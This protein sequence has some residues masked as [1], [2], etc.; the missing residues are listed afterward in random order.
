MFSTI[1][2]INCEITFYRNG[3]VDYPENYFEEGMRNR[4][5]MINE[6]TLNLKDS[7]DSENDCDD[8]YDEN[9]DNGMSFDSSDYDDD[10]SSQSDITTSTSDGDMSETDDDDDD[11]NIVFALGL[12]DN[13]KVKQKSY[14]GWD[15][16]TC[17][18]HTD[19]GS[20]YVGNGKLPQSVY[21]NTID[22]GHT[23]GC[24]YIP[25]EYLA[26]FTING[27]IVKQTDVQSTSSFFA[28]TL[29]KCEGFEINT[30]LKPFKFD[31]YQRSI[32]DMFL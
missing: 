19:N 12:T 28:F 26:F 17:A 4:Q 29:S 7:K 30:G 27:Q 13:L 8:C 11:T 9:N 22:Y 16:G 15:L 1:C 23:I 5:Q 3:G 25:S 31:P 21:R 2:R 20:C 18:F 10:S 6:Y 24:G 32:N 14:L